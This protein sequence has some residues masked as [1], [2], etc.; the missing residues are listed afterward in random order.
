MK[1]MI[2]KAALRNPRARPAIATANVSIKTKSELAAQFLPS[3]VTQQID[4]QKDKDPKRVKQK[5][6]N[7]LQE[8]VAQAYREKMYT[9]DHNE[10]LESMG[11][12]SGTQ[13]QYNLYSMNPF[14]FI[15]Q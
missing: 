1:T 9:S 15:Q 10:M 12:K 4:K 13:D 6:L 14:E 11:V 2:E 5:R 3:S 8:I 7:S